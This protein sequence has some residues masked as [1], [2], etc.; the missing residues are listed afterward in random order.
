MNEGFTVN[1]GLCVRVKII[2]RA[3]T[4][5]SRGEKT[6]FEQV[7]GEGKMTSEKITW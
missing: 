6:S 4:E 3:L 5:Q 1:G 7:K 2:H